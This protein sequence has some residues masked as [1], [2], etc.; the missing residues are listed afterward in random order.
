MELLYCCCT[1]HK[2]MNTANK[3]NNINNPTKTYSTMNRERYATMYAPAMI[4]KHE[5]QR[6]R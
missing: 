3:E 2:M 5:T 4:T 6:R 1:Y